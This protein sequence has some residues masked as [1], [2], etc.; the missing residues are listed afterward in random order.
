MRP[1]LVGL[2]PSKSSNPLEPMSGRSGAFLAHLLGMSLPRF[3]WS[4]GRVNLV[5]RWP[6]RSAGGSDLPPS[7][8]AARR[9]AQNLAN[10]G[11]LRGRSVVLLGREVAW[12]FHVEQSTSFF[13]RTRLRAAE[14]A[15]AWLL[16]H[17]SGVCRVWN[18]PESR[19]RA[20]WVLRRAL[21]GF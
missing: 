3:L 13:A 17:P 6:G 10:S 16:P 21:A 1:I 18:T 15:K 14:E 4:F 12:A 8:E 11:F 20:V 7:R 9:C 19:V 2:A 5:D